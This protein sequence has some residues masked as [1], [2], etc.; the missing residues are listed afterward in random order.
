M[1]GLA[2]LN[3]LRNRA[4]DRDLAVYLL[5]PSYHPWNLRPT[6]K[7]TMRPTDLPIFENLFQSLDHMM[8][9]RNDLHLDG[10]LALRPNPSS[11]SNK[12]L[13][14]ST[15]QTKRLTISFAASTQK[16]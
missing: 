1:R 12:L 9:H 11:A 14:Y 8:T 6:A 5:S 7:E 3:W 16:R 13:E 10:V 2:V 4:S 15:V